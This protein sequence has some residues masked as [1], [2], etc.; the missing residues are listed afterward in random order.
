MSPNDW[1]RANHLLG[2]VMLV[3]QAVVLVSMQALVETMDAR[4]GNSQVGWSVS[5]ACLLAPDST[6][7][8]AIRSC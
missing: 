6:G 3:S 7:A 2:Y 8:G 5:W 4:F 1:Q